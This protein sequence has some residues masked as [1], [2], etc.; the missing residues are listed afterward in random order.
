MIKKNANNKSE[1]N[2]KQKITLSLVALGVV[3]GD[4][5]TS[6]LYT[7]RTIFSPNTH[8]GLALSTQNVFGI[9]SVIF[10]SLIMV[11][12]IKYI[13]FI[14]KAN[15]RGEGGIMA[16]IS[17]VSQNLHANKISNHIMF[18]GII[19]AAMFY[20]DAMIT[21]A[22][23]V[24]SASEGLEIIAPSLKP[25]II[26]LTLI[27]L[28]VL[29][30]FQSSGTD[31]IGK[32]FGP[33]MLCWFII[34]GMLG[35][36]KI[37]EMPTILYA[38]NPFYAI[39]FFYDNTVIAFIAISAVTL[40]ITGA[41]AL[42]VDMGHFGRDPIKIAWIFVALPALVLNYFGQGVLILLDPNTIK[43]PFYLMCPQ[44][45]TILLVII[46]NIA[47][48][49]ASQ[50]VITGVFSISK[51][52]A[53][54]GFLPRMHIEH[55]S[56]TAQEG[57]IYIAKVNWILMV[58]TMLLVLIFNSSSNL[59]AVY[60]IAVTANM[61][62]TT[63]LSA[64]V[65]YQLWGWNK[66]KTVLF[67]MIFFSL[68]ALFFSANI[69][70]ML[71]GGLF[72]IFVMLFFLILMTTWKKGKDILY[73]KL[74]HESIDLHQFI[75]YIQQNKPNIVEGVAVFLTPSSTTPYTL[76]NN[77]KHNKII[78]QTVI[79]LR[80]IFLNYPNVAKD[81]GYH[82]ENLSSDDLSNKIYKLELYYGFKDQPNIPNDLKRCINENNLAI[83]AN[84]LDEISYF[85]GNETLIPYGKAK[86][87]LW[88]KRLFVNL[89]ENSDTVTKQFKLPPNR[90]VEIG[91][92][93]LF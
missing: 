17:L 2:L 46:A 88:R 65:F 27:I 19:G 48:I 70:K 69:L 37:I 16:L 79:I 22:I 76:I 31:K 26:P 25:F 59:A 74:K 90:V 61:M 81:D 75:D 1:H 29:F 8:H 80:V 56:K 35:I 83:E 52:A 43:N 24:L 67:I 39:N 5:G 85:I 64:I 33:I 44:P 7:M 23:S 28:F 45:L 41:E 72:I 91:R 10:W 89:F 38:L 20:A 14:M 71:H 13:S 86:M 66:W 18:F 60:G 30:Y 11:V 51:Q 77:L 4:I 6:P 62:I 63:A 73:K 47:T 21:P 57:Q 68:D 15:N 92:Q 12:S 82:I 49:I 55:T 84:N 3:F 53:Q 32:F 87:H 34:I 58:S 78:H 50:A 40:A 54:L 36:L 42:Y 93:V 9:L